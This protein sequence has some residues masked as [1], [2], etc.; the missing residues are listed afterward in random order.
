MN[1]LTNITLKFETGAATHVG[2]VR[3]ANEDSFIARPDLGL[4]A[5]A[6]GVGGHEAGQLASSTVAEELASIGPAVSIDDQIARFQAR[7]FRANSSIHQLAEERGGAMMGTTVVA[8][9]AFDHE[10]SILWAG[11]S[12]AYLQRGAALHP[13]S[14]DHSEVQE[15][16]DEGVIDA[17]QAKTW[18]RRNVITR[19]IG[20]FDEPQLECIKGD[21]H[22]GDTFVLCSDGLT[23]H[24]SDADI[25]H[26]LLDQRAQDACDAM[27]ETTLQRGGSDNVTII[28]VR[29]H[30]AERTHLIPGTVSE[31]ARGEA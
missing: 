25:L 15:L 19:A 14:R 20:I 10:F 27:I 4:W 3:Q 11:D 5:V 16:L 24:L 22:S 6:D 28:V 1:Q 12:R 29:C 23:G 17:E 7:I 21:I 8:A 9:L 18:P 30:H 2:R 13:L 31:S 26:H